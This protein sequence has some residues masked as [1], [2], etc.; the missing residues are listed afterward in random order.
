MKILAIA[1]AIVLSAALGAFGYHVYLTQNPKA[2]AQY[3]MTAYEQARQEADRQAVQAY[4]R[5]VATVI[6]AARVDAP[7]VALPSDCRRG[8]SLG[9]FDATP[10][11][12][13]ATCTVTV[14]STGKYGI[15]ART[16]AGAVAALG[17]Y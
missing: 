6:E 10:V 12:L 4:V 5:N 3:V 7:R 1:L 2:G 13:L 11:T 14:E 9:G 15:E 8:Y 16:A 17:P